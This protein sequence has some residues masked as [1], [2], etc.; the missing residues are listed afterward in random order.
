MLALCEKQNTATIP[1]PLEEKHL[2]H[3][4]WDD[5]DSTSDYIFEFKAKISGFHGL[6]ALAVKFS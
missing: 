6:T 2:K 5:S 1:Q 4:T 3:F